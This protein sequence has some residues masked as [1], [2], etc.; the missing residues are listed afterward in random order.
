M[1][2]TPVAVCDLSLDFQPLKPW[3]RPLPSVSVEGQI[4]CGFDRQPDDFSL[5]YSAS[6]GLEVFKTCHPNL[7]FLELLRFLAKAPSWVNVCE[8]WEAYQYRNH[9]VIEDLSHWVLKLPASFLTWAAQKQLQPQEIM[10]AKTFLDQPHLLE[11]L[12]SWEKLNPSHGQG[13][14][15]LALL[16]DLQAPPSFSNLS[17]SDYLEGLKKLRYPVTTSQDEQ[18][19]KA[20]DQISFP[21]GTQKQFVRRGDDAG[22]ELRYFVKNSGEL[23]AQ[24]EKTLARLGAECKS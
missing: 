19:R 12:E 15:I 10:V 3:P 6:E 21:K 4:I 14:Q 8:F 13:M 18:R 24:L 20:W 9:F 23:K 7:S 11:I 5:D 17:P 2:M 22:L 1:K 16:A